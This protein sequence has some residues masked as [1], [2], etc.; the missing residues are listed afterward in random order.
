MTSLKYRRRYPR[1]SVKVYKKRGALC[2]PRAVSI[3]TGEDF[4]EVCRVFDRFIREF[5]GHNDASQNHLLDYFNLYRVIL[6]DRKP[7]ITLDDAYNEFG[8]GVYL[9]STPY[10]AT[11]I[12]D[13]VML[14]HTDYR[15]IRT[16]Y[17]VKSCK[18]CRKSWERKGSFTKTLCSGRKDRCGFCGKNRVQVYFETFKPRRVRDEVW[19]V[20]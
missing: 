18:S 9:L 12:I 6:P 19:K 3:L 10:H 5:G 1:S 20:M 4:G 14:D 8:D 17:K 11:T 7:G 13:G 16:N 15:G 2:V